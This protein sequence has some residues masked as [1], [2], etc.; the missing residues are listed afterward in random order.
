MDGNYSCRFGQYNKTD[1]VIHPSA[2]FFSCCSVLY[3][4]L[5]IVVFGQLFFVAIEKMYFIL[6][7]YYM[8]IIYVL[9]FGGLILFFLFFTTKESMVSSS[10]VIPLNLFQTWTTHELPPKM[11]E[12]VTTLQQNNPEFHYT[13]MDDD[14]CEEFIEDNFPEEVAMAYRQLIPGAYKAD[15][16]RYC[17]LYIFGGIYLDIKYCTV[18]GFKLTSL[19]D[20]EYFVKDRKQENDEHCIYNAFMICKPGNIKLKQC[21]DAIVE[22]CKT[23]Y[24]GTSSLAPTGPILLGRFFTEEE[25]NNIVMFHRTD[26]IVYGDQPILQAFD[27]YRSEQKKTS[28]K[29]HYG[30]L[31]N[32]K[33]IY[34]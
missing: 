5:E 12:C 19:T 32:E 31:W 14:E 9:I 8:K 11:K 13:L 29:K 22:N 3:V 4:I 15:L 25:I 18:P 17:V 34:R 23:K 1:L 2:G 10:P 28:T 27:E 20:K 24:Y 6:L 26:R 7:K 30:I 33:A 16:W 21:I